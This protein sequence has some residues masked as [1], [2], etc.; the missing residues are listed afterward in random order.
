MEVVPFKAS[1]QD[2]DDAGFSHF[3]LDVWVFADIEKN[4]EGNEKEFVLF[5]DEDIEFFELSFGSDF[6]LFIIPAPHFNILT[7][8]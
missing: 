8:E 5:P 6:V 4:V 2:L 7:I 1:A 3:F